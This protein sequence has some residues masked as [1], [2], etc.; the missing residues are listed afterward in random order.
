MNR[1]SFEIATVCEDLRPRHEIGAGIGGK[2][3]MAPEGSI[4]FPTW[5]WPCLGSKLPGRGEHI[6]GWW[7]GTSILFSHILGF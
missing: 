2:V 5:K 3:A 7:F 6:T 4:V 1:I